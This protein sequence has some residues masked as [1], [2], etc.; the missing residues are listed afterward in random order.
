M[1]LKGK[2]IVK[3]FYER[4]AQYSYFKGGSTGGRMA[5]M[6]AERYPEDYDGIIA[7]SL[8]SGHIHPTWC[9]GNADTGP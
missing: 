2:Q 8:A 1:T 9:A 5:L 6:E 3:A 4:G 7:G